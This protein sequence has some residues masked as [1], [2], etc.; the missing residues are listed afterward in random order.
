MNIHYFH[1][2]NK[3]LLYKEKIAGTPS[4][5]HFIPFQSTFPTPP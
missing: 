1:N 4:F 3:K 2:K 5:F